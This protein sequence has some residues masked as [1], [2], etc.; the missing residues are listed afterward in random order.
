MV[1]HLSPARYIVFKSR[2]LGVRDQLDINAEV[3]ADRMPTFGDIGERRMVEMIRGIVTR[4]GCPD[5]LEDDAAV[6][7]IP[8]GD[9][10][11]CTDALTFERH[12]PAGMTYEQFGW[13]CAAANVSD[14]ASMGARPVGLLVSM[15]VPVSM[16]ASDICD[17][18]SGID[19]CAEFADTY[20]IGGDTKPGNGTVAVTALGSMDG[21]RPMTRSGSRPGDMI[22]VTGPLGGPAAGFEALKNGI[23]LPDSVAS[24]MTPIPR[25]D[26]GIRLSESGLVTSCM[27]LSDG[28]STC[29]NT[30]CKASGTGAVIQWDFLP[31]DEGVQTINRVLGIP[32][33]DMLMDWGGEYELLFTFGSDDHEAIA[34]T[35]VD[36]HI[37][38]IMTEKDV[39]LRRDEKYEVIA[40]GRY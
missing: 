18:A 10:V 21:R 24:L 6:I 16:D 22:A 14:L 26:E 13:M 38:G 2:A 11:A 15:N 40:D 7:R 4:D 28:L 36:F 37:I 20:I 34:A 3:D 30:L 5:S 27:D 12:M 8:S 35:G 19:Q 33:K 17:I 32:E 39:L 25:V 31:A 9:V 29:I 1:T 23:E